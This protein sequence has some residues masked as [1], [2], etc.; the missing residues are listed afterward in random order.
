M[1]KKMIPKVPIN[2]KVYT[3]ASIR[4]WFL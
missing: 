1:A 4:N 2:K 3:S